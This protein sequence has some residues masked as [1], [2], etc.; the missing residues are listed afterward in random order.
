MG[1]DHGA[2]VV[3]PG[4]ALAL[5]KHPG[6]TFRLYGDKT[7]IEPLLNKAPALKA[8][9]TVIHT[10][11]AVKMDDQPSQAL[12][13]GR[14]KSSMWR[15]IQAVKDGEADAVV[16]AGNT[17]ALMAMAKVC[18]RTM[19]GVDRPSI[20]CLWPTP[21]G[22]CIVLD[23]GASI[24]AEAEDLVNMAVLGA[25]MAKIVLGKDCPTVGLLNIGT[26][27]VKGLDN[28]KQAS[29]LLKKMA[30]VGFEYK[31]FVEGNDISKG[32]TDVVITEGFAGNIALKT[33]EGTARL[34]TSFL[35]EAMMSSARNKLGYAFAKPA[36]D[37][38][39]EKLDPRKGNGGVFL[40]LEGIVVKSHGST[41]DI[42]YACAIG[43][44]HD[45]VRH[46]LIKTIRGLFEALHVPGVPTEEGI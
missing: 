32:T 42:G 14:G 19:A 11:V 3:I 38:L 33:A 23:V 5:E 28:I 27:E 30:S 13:R 7:V 39:K 21:Q 44:A 34:L 20:S 6:L 26:E 25:A 8:V 16:S 22:F 31:G 15:A 29:R 40:G 9:S 2:A 24:G 1:G 46:N 35:R 36:F 12:R 43:I 41:D 45:M 4:A 17:G 37:A 10:D 18:L